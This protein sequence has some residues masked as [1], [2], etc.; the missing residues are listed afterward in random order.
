MVIPHPGP[1]TQFTQF[2]N[3]PT[4]SISL[5]YSFSKDQHYFTN[6]H[7]PINLSMFSNSNATM[8]CFVSWE[9]TPTFLVGWSPSLGSKQT[10]QSHLF[11]CCDDVSLE[12]NITL[13]WQKSSLI[14]FKM[15][16]G[17]YNSLFHSALNSMLNNQKHT[18][19]LKS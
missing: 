5:L 18:E 19:S 12:S 4:H 17:R 13:G 7:L 8:L 14:T 3:W 1:H 16:H 9:A 6:V 10:I 15:V 11:T 2:V